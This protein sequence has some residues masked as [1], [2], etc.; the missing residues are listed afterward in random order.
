MAGRILSMS[1]W[2]ELTASENFLWSRTFLVNICTHMDSKVPLR[3]LDN[4]GAQA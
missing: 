3:Q 2:V 4:D 1:S